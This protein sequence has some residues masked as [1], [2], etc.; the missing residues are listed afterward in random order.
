MKKSLFLRALILFSFLMGLF[1]LKSEVKA[2]NC[3]DP[4]ISWPPPAS[5]DYSGCDNNTYY[6]CQSN[7][8][9]DDSNNNI[10]RRVKSG[11][12]K[13]RPV[14]CNVFLIWECGDWSSCGGGS[15]TINTITNCAS[16]E[17]CI[18]NTSWQLPNDDYCQC[19]EYCLNNPSSLEL[20]DGLGQINPPNTNV[21]LPV[22]FVWDQVPGANSY[23]YRAWKID[24]PTTTEW[25]N[26]QATT[27]GLIN[28]SS[29]TSSGT[30]TNPV[31]VIPDS[32]NKSPC[33]LT[34]PAT[35]T[36]HQS[37]STNWKIIPCC[38]ADGTK[39][40]DWNEV[41]TSSFVLS[42]AP[43]LISPAD[44]DWNN[45][46]N[47]ATS[48]IPV[49]LSWC[50]VKEAEIFHL[51]IYEI[52]NVGTESCPRLL[53]GGG[54]CSYVSVSKPP[55]RPNQSTTIEFKDSSV[56][57]YFISNSNYRWEVESCNFSGGKYVCSSSSQKWALKTEDIS[58]TPPAT[59]GLRSPSNQTSTSTGLPVTLNWSD[60]IGLNS[61]KYILYP[62]DFIG[63][64]F[65]RFATISI[66]SSQLILPLNETPLN[67][68][69]YW[70]I[71]GCYDYEAKDCGPWASPVSW[72][73]KTTG[74]PPSLISPT[75]GE[76]NVVV[77]VR[78]DWQ[79]IGG[80]KAYKIEIATDSLFTNTA[81][82]TIVIGASELLVDAPTLRTNTNYWW[83][84]KTCADEICT[85]Y[86]STTLPIS[87][88]TFDLLPPDS[89]SPADGFIILEGKRMDFSWSSVNGAK[90]YNYV[91]YAPDG[92]E[93]FNEIS[94]ANNASYPLAMFPKTGIYTWKVKSCLD[95][96]CSIFSNWS[97][98]GTPWSFD[99][100]LI[101]GADQQGGVVPC[102]REY[103]DPRTPWNERE[104]CQIKHF[105]LLIRNILDFI[106]LKIAT[107][108][109]ILILLTAAGLFFASKGEVVVMTQIK[110]FVKAA[111][112][113]YAII[114]GAWFFINAFLYFL[115]YQF[116]FF[117][118]WWGFS[119]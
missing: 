31:W 10:E 57:P 105:F 118:R 22:K 43:Q 45:P 73:F 56:V 100:K 18:G 35:S 7:N 102:G 51:K 65:P 6:R 33:L 107:I 11:Y 50:N 113:G 74:E 46:I 58:S 117:G 106:F 5:T 29:A 104:S 42:L 21:R 9:C 96:N 14:F 103:D 83:R 82:E 77:P 114:F 61:F 37:T 119:I 98:L 49:K 20:W 60:A 44:P 87:F 85:I 89:P 59:F 68:S 97:N 88:S 84:V 34:L 66:G 75:S 2:A 109:I 95:I 81:K 13:T 86:G 48:D 112:I 62:V 116:Q 92:T 71:L 24:P 1:F 115:G 69:F 93:L 27:S 80:A 16:Y 36:Y 26:A 4:C 25:N 28:S 94:L 17:T 3:G 64:P 91:I 72:V 52:D 8:D 19:Q 54:F 30:S 78:F 32:G 55:F 70:N 101:A 76:S 38:N 110:S 63:P 67:K 12:Y 90:A 41:S 23:W 79:D 47:F 108:L 40:K 15:D 99:L 39:C 111:L 53:S